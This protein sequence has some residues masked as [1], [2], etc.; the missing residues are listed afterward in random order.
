[1][2]KRMITLIIAVMAI[3]LNAI[4]ANA[5]CLSEDGRPDIIG[6]EHF[7]KIDEICAREEFEIEYEINMYCVEDYWVVSITGKAD[8]LEDY[9]AFGMYDHIPNEEEINTLW[10]NRML[11][12]EL[13][14]LAEQYASCKD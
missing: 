4:N 8:G 7:D 14:E 12:D 13:Y 1:M 9:M 5:M 10:A 6:M 11:E 2:F 3:S